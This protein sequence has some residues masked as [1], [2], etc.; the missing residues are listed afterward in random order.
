MKATLLLEAVTELP[1]CISL[2]VE[3]ARFPAAVQQGRPQV[4]TASV[5]LADDPIDPHPLQ[6]ASQK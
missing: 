4:A 1:R 6:V 5:L 3:A 2:E